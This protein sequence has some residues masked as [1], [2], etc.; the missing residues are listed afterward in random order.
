MPRTETSFWIRSSP[1]RMPSGW[2]E[3]RNASAWSA[4]HMPR[5]RQLAELCELGPVALEFGPL[6]LDDRGWSLCDEAFICELALGALDLTFELRATLGQTLFGLAGVDLRR[7][8]HLDGTDRGQRLASLGVEVQSRKPRD[9]LVRRGFVACPGGQHAA[10]GDAAE[11]PP[12]PDLPNGLDGSGE[13]GLSL[14]VKARALGFR[15]PG[16]HQQTPSTR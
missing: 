10:G 7:R 6:R 9:E 8:K 2:R 1:K 3:A 12:A 14:F 13:F 11:F 4:V 15:E 5:G 16:R